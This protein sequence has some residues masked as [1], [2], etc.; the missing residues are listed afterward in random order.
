MTLETG[1]DTAALLNR[2]RR[3]EGQIRG[4]QRMLEED[5]YCEDVLNQILAVRS[6]V[7]QAGLL[8]LDYHINCCVLAGAK[9]DPAQLEALRNALRMW[10]RFTPAAET[11]EP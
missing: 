8:V 7:D 3:L 6:G 11:A 9:V 2:L 10:V 5:R 4:I 1:A